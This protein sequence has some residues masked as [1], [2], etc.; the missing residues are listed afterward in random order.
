MAKSAIWISYDLGIKGDYASLY[1]WL[2]SH[3]AKECGDSVAFLTYEHDGDVR[4]TLEADL[5]SAINIE[6]RARIYMIYREK[7][8]GK[9]RGVFLF[10]GRRAPPWTGYASKGG[11]TAD[12][13]EL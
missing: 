6:K 9:N 2:D 12:E 10:G 13:E 7:D 11:G 5:Q 3:G 4:A 1:A 8:T